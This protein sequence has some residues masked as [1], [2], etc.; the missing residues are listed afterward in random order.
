MAERAQVTSVEAIDKFRAHLIVY[1][2]K[3]RA[4]VEE[5]SGEVSRTRQWIQGDQ[6]KNWSDELRRRRK[7]LDAA[8]SELSSARLSLMDEATAG[9]QMA[10]RR[11]RDSVQ[12][13]ENKLSL[14]K[15]WDRELE[16]IAEPL[17]RQTN[18]L[19]HVLNNDLPRAVAHL[20]QISRA[21][22]AYRD[23]VSGTNAVAPAAQSEPSDG[24]AQP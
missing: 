16:H 2:T 19:Q 13:A 4:L 6:R 21:L 5:V 7:K 9:Q 22:A 12:E 10:V 3:T 15:K 14:L 23:V 24:E 8:M 20:E 1:A 17:V 18:G 11:A